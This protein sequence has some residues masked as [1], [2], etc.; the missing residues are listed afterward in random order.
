MNWMGRSILNRLLGISALGL[1][2]LLVGAFYCFW[3]VWHSIRM[4]DVEVKARNNEAMLVLA[5][6]AEFKKQVQE[7]KDVLLRGGDPAALE[8]YWG[9]FETQ[10]KKVQE[11]ILRLLQ[12]VNDP[13]SR[14]FLQDFQQAHKKM[15]EDYRQGLQAFKDSGSDSKAGDAAVKG[16]DRAP[17]E[18]LTQAAKAIAQASDDASRQ[19][20]ASGYGGIRGGLA[21]MALAALLASAVLVWMVRKGIVQPAQQTVDGLDRLA[22]GDFSRA[23]VCATQDEI[24]RI[25]ASGERIRIELREI[26]EEIASASDELVA[27]SA[28][29]AGATS[30]LTQ[31]SGVQSEKSSATA[32][33]VEQMTGSIGMVAESAEEMRQL[34]NASLEQAQEGNESL[35]KLGLE[36]GRVGAAVKEIA[37]SINQFVDSTAT[38]TNM[39][40]QV[41]EIA[42]Q[43]NLLALNAAIEAA[44]AGEQGRGFA[45]VADEVRKLAEKSSQS[46]NEIDAVTQALGQQSETVERVIHQGMQSIEAGQAMMAA[47]SSVLAQATETVGRV[48]RGMGDIALSVREQRAASN[49]IAINVEGIAQMA[50]EN[51][52]AIHQTD[53][54]AAHLSRVADQLRQVVTR[55]KM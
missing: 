8:K 2:L 30:Q 12:G 27:A 31:S 35:S 28:S 22:E 13:E 23:L 33:A 10:E 45:V 54:E 21:L 6:Q 46:A 1:G 17:T 43:T 5:T 24:G 9:H 38:I 16:M 20:V 4:F 53:E 49:E 39:T 40:Q 15:G 47:V 19:A 32:A 11:N 55:F 50:E 25:A 29:L 36:V 52:A 42:D 37:D 26:L 3:L 51:S 34:A 48:S 14:K 7:W 18:L 41:K 44:R